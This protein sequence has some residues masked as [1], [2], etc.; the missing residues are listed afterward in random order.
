[1]ASDSKCRTFCGISLAFFNQSMVMLDEHFY[2]TNVLL[3][4]DQL[5]L[6][7]Y[8]LKYNQPFTAVGIIF[9]IS[10][11]TVAIIFGSILRSHSRIVRKYL[12]WPS[13]EAIKATMP[14]AFKLHFPE[15]R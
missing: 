3:P 5:V 9:G 6:Y 15:T 2:D 4:E 10:E 1:M 12:E 11:K 13:R 7:Y 14:P 8:K